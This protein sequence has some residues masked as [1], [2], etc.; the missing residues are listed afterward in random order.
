MNFLPEAQANGRETNR[1]E[2]QIDFFEKS[3]ESALLGGRN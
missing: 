1:F 2:F 3:I